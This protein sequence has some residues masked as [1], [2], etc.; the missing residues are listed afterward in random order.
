MTKEDLIA[1]QDLVLHLFGQHA[2]VEL[3][4]DGSGYITI[5]DEIA[6]EAYFV[7]DQ[8]RTEVTRIT[9]TFD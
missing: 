7:F 3:E 9:L 2:N 1:A 6:V 5:G 8:Y 4:D